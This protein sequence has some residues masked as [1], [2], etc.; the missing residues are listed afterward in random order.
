[1]TTPLFRVFEAAIREFQ[2]ERT[3][4]RPLAAARYD[5][6]IFPTVG[7]YDW[8]SGQA[9]YCLV[10]HL[11]PEAIVEVSTSSGYSTLF[12][13]LALKRNGKGHIRTF[14]MDPRAAAAAEKNFRRWEVDPFVRLHVGDARRNV[15]DRTGK[16]ASLLFLDSLHSERFARW[17]L[18]CLVASPPADS[19]FHMHDIMP[20]DA[21]VRKFGGPPFPPDR[22][23]SA[24]KR[25]KNAIR[26]RAPSDEELPQSLKAVFPPDAANPLP[27]YDGN[28]TTEAVFGNRLAGKLGADDKA[29]C[30]HIADRF[31]ELGP[32]D[33]DHVVVGWEDGHGRP[34]EWNE[35]LW[36]YA[37]RIAEAYASL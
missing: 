11:K 18:E 3:V 19:L 15:T 32:R 17:F 28:D 25:W 29:Y 35:S 1:M 13:G 33:F 10:R 31:P 37:G 9:L 27:T 26:G 24:F 12:M 2:A 22:K 36:A 14:E 20:T 34:L 6:T 16:D 8:F 30:H 4:L 7:Q 5:R 23:K 21:R